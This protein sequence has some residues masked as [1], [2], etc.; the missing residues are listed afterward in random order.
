MSYH[1]FITCR[2]FISSWAHKLRSHLTCTLGILI[3]IYHTSA[4]YADPD[5]FKGKQIVL[6]HSGGDGGGYSQYAQIFAPFF[7]KHIEGQPRIIVQ[8]M[9]GAGGVRMMQYFNTLAPRDGTYIGFVQSGVTILP[10]LKKDEHSYDPRNFMWLGAMS[11]IPSICV[12]MTSTGIATFDD[13]QTKQFIVG[14]SG[15]GSLTE[16]QPAILNKLFGTKIKI[17]SGYHGAS[18][19]YLAM[20]RG[21]LEGRCGSGLPSIEL[22]KPQWI[23]DHLI[24]V[25][26]QFGMQR[27]RDL[28]DVP[29]IYELARD[30]HTRS[31]LK[32]ILTP[33]EMN[34]PLFTSP[35]VPAAQVSLLQKAFHDTLNDPE[36]LDLAHA[37][38]L[39]IEEN[40]G[41]N[42]TSL[43]QDVYSLPQD[44]IDIARDALSN[45]QHDQ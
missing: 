34:R 8:T 24:N 38:K 42:I 6:I 9:P 14:S 29:N 44:I 32:I 30:E 2:C 26:I 15:S 36:F 5:L 27:G 39:E 41:S 17:I 7:A 20:E 45:A 31:V 25:P 28:P 43:I 21:E 1:H 33:V 40:S 18:D 23:K 12:A 3:L 37:N 19:I 4:V 16:A 13:L 11:R 35:Q 22:A 10:L